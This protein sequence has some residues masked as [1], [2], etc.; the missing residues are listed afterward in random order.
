M[1]AM[2][3]RAGAMTL[4][5]VAVALLLAS[6]PARTAESTSDRRYSLPERGY[7]QVKAP[8]SQDAR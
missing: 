8:A 7:F 5:C 2:I 1:V 3:T 4:S 6:G